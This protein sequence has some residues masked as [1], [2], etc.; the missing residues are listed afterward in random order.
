MGNFKLNNFCQ[1]MDGFLIVLNQ[2]GQVVYVN[3]TVAVHLGLSQVCRLLL[4]KNLPNK[5]L[6][7]FN[8]FEK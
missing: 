8:E 7:I 3:E 2:E 4:G 6:T 5:N 1:A